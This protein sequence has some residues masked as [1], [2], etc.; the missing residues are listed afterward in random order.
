MSSADCV[1]A[2]GG[3]FSAH[4]SD[5]LQ[6]LR[7]GVA[8]VSRAVKASEVWEA[9]VGNNAPPAL[10]LATLREIM[11]SV[12]QYQPHTTE[13]GFT[14]IGRMPKNEVKLIM[15]LSRHKAEEAEHGLWA[16]RDYLLLGGTEAGVSAPAS[17]AVF[18]VIGVWDRLGSSEEPLSYLG[19][20]YLF[21]ALTMELAPTVMAALERKGAKRGNVG[22]LA[23][24][25]VEDEKH[26]RL[27]DH[28]VLDVGTRHPRSC[29]A[30]L[31]SFEYFA[32]VYPLPVWTEALR[33]AES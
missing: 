6:A 12:L 29:Q 3:E 7:T 30:M 26:T 28:W 5:T 10:S 4:A 27:L 21:E 8:R 2:H 11:W 15:S 9:V 32:E 23:E 14:M 13:A 19:A 20:E 17:P 18:A 1:P 22:F 33:R 31:R 16:R 24:H 25:A